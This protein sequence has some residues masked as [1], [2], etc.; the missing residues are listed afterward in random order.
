[1]F[2]LVV[3]LLGCAPQSYYYHGINLLSIEFTLA[4][5][6]HGI[7]PN[8]QILGHETNPFPDPLFDAKWEIESFGHP[9][10]SYYAWASQ[11]AVEP[12]GENQYYTAM[13][14]TNLYQFDMVDEYERYYVWDMAVRAHEAVLLNFSDS[15]SYL[16]DGVSSFPLAPLSYA[17][18]ETLGADVS[19]WVKL[20]LDDGSVI[21]IA[22]E[23]L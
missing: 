1:M 4:S 3:S 18:L 10:A 17:A 6:E 9:P 8:S 12:T 2:L 23:D 15:V 19:D 5:D 14:L 16:Q 22:K 11:I 21:I 13:A 20:S 7:Y